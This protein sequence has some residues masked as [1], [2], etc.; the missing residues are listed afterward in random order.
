[1][2]NSCIYPVKGIDDELAKAMGRD[3]KKWASHIAVMRNLYEKTKG[4]KVD[5]EHMIATAEKFLQL[6]SQRRTDYLNTY[7]VRH[8]GTIIAEQHKHL[9]KVMD[10]YKR[11]RRTSLLAQLFSTKVDMQYMK[12]GNTRSRAEIMNGYLDENG[13][14]R[15]GQFRIFEEMRIDIINDISRL[16]EKGTAEDMHKAQEYMLMLEH[17]PALVTRARLELTK[18]EGIKLSATAETADVATFEDYDGNGDVNIA[19]ALDE[20]VREHWMDKAETRSAYGS[21]G[22]KVRM[23]LGRC[24]Q[25]NKEGKI[26]RDDI[27]IPVLMNPIRTHQLLQKQLRFCSSESSMMKKLSYI[28]GKNKG[29]ARIAWM[30]GIVDFL[31]E[32]PQ[33]RTIFFNDFNKNRTLYSALV[34]SRKAGSTGFFV[35]NLN[36]KPTAATDFYMLSVL[37]K[38]PINTATSIFDGNGYVN[39]KNLQIIRN[40]INNNFVDV[41]DAG[42][43]KFDVMT[44]DKKIESIMDLMER[45][46]M[47]I[48]IDAASSLVNDAGQLKR[49]TRNIREFYST[50]INA[51]LDVLALQKGPKAR[52]S[53]KE[54]LRT[55]LKDGSYDFNSEDSPFKGRGKVSYYEFLTTTREKIGSPLDY[56]SKLFETVDYYQDSVAYEAAAK[57][58]NEQGKYISYYPDVLPSYMA[59]RIENIQSFVKENDHK[60]LRKWIE[61]EFL[62]NNPFFAEKVDGKWV[63]F[64]KWIDELYQASLN[65]SVPLDERKKGKSPALTAVFEMTRALGS[66]TDVTEKYNRKQHMTDMFTRFF[67]DFERGNN[68]SNL[69]NMLTAWFPVFVL[70]DSNAH[71]Y[72]HAKVYGN[73]EILRGFYNIFRQE[74]RRWEMQLAL[75][76]DLESKGYSKL[77]NFDDRLIEVEEIDG[78]E[79]DKDA[80]LQKHGITLESENGITDREQFD[81]GYKETSVKSSSTEELQSEA[82]DILETSDEMDYMLYGSLVKI[83]EELNKRGETV[84]GKDNRELTLLRTKRKIIKGGEFTMLKFLNPWH[85]ANDGTVGKYY[86]M[87]DAE[88]SEQSVTNAIQAYLTDSEKEVKRELQKNKL[89]KKNRK[90]PYT[91][92]ALPS[93]INTK[94]L[95]TAIQ[96]Y[97]WNHAFATAQQLQMFTI[98]PAFYGLGV[99]K[100]GRVHG[101]SKD[102]QKRYKQEHA[103]G[104]P[105][106]LEAMYDDKTYVLPLTDE[107]E[108]DETY[109]VVYFDDISTSAEDTDPEMME[110]LK[111][112]YGKDSWEVDQYKD[113]SLTD[114]QGYRTLKGYRK[115]ATMLGEWTDEMTNAYNEIESIR[116]SAQGREFTT[117]EMQRIIDCAAVFQP[118]KPIMYGIEKYNANGV[119]VPIPVQHKYAEAIIIPELCAPNSRI[120][121]I[122]EWMD[123][124]NV[125]M[126]CSTKAVKVG[127]F[128][129]VDISEAKSDEDIDIALSKAYQHELR[130]SDWRKQTNVPNHV[131][132]SRLFGNQLRK[133]IMSNLDFRSGKLYNH[134]AGGPV[135]I[136][137]KKGEKVNLNAN[138]LVSFY[139]SLIYSNMKESFEEFQK[140]I[141]SSENISETLLQ[142]I[143]NNNRESEDHMLAVALEELAEGR[144]FTLALCE[145]G[146]EHDTAAMLW[147]IFRKMVNKQTIMGNSLVQV[148]ALGINSIK[149]ESE[150]NVNGGLKYQMSEDGENILWAEAEIPWDLVF[151]LGDTHIPLRWE[152]YCNADRTLKV[153]ENGIPLIEKVLPG[154]LDMIAY[155]IPTEREYSMV[156]LKVVRFAPPSE[157]GTIK[158]PAPAVTIAGFDFDIDKLYLMRKEFQRRNLTS[159][160]AGEIWKE[161]Y[162]ENREI[163]KALELAREQ[164]RGELAELLRE[165]II[166]SV[167][168]HQ[169]EDLQFKNQR[170]YRWWAEAGL[171]ETTGFATPEEAFKDFFA[172]TPTL[173]KYED[174]NPELTPEQNSRAA[175]NNMLLDIMMRRLEDPETLTARTTPGGFESAKQA[176]RILRELLYGDSTGLSLEELDAKVR[177]KT[178][179]DPEPDY[180]VLNPLTMIQYTQQ[181]QIASKL[182]GIFAN[183]NSNYA[184]TSI[185][186]SLKISEADPYGGR[187]SFAGHSYNDFLNP[188]LLTDSKGNVLKDHKGN[189]RYVDV[190]RL[191]AEFLAAS[192]DAVKD[193]VLNYLNLN[194]ITA[195]IGATL[196][197]LGYTMNE[198][199]LLLNQ[200]AIREVCKICNETGKPVD[201]VIRNICEEAKIKMSETYNPNKLSIENLMKEIED[202]RELERSAEV[203]SREDGDFIEAEVNWNG[204]QT[205]VL[206]LFNQLV[207]ISGDLSKL[208]TGTKFTASNAVDSTFGGV[209]AK[210]HKVKNFVKSLSSQT[211]TIVAEMKD[212]LYYQREDNHLPINSSEHLLSLSEKEYYDYIVDNPFG[213]EQAMFDFM[214]KTLNYLCKKETLIENGKAK[215]K[216]GYYPYMTDTY[217]RT[218]N[219]ISALTKSGNLNDQFINTL[220]MDMLVAMLSNREGSLFDG[221]SLVEYGENTITIRDY[222]QNHFASD[223][224]TTIM[225]REDLKNNLLFKMLSPEVTRDV[226]GAIENV[227][228]KLAN[229]GGLEE[230]TK[231]QLIEA[232]ENLNRE[233]KDIARNLFLYNFY[234]KGFSYGFNTFLNLAPTSL[235]LDIMIDDGRASK[236]V[237]YADFF[238]NVLNG[239]YNLNP[240]TFAR[241][242]IMNNS[243]NNKLVF[244]ADWGTAKKYLESHSEANPYYT[245][246]NSKGKKERRVRKVITI[247]TSKKEK[248]SSGASAFYKTTKIGD[249]LLYNF[250][251]AI[252]YDGL[253]YI[254]VGDMGEAIANKTNTNNNFEEGFTDANGFNVTYKPIMNYVVSE[255]Y[256][257]NRKTYRSE[258]L[259]EDVIA[260]RIRTKEQLEGYENKYTAK[261]YGKEIIEG[262]KPSE[263]MT[264]EENQQQEE[265]AVDEVTKEGY[266][267]GE[268]PE[269]INIDSVN[270]ALVALSAMIVAQRKKAK[271]IRIQNQQ[272]EIDAIKD[273]AKQSTKIP[274]ALKQQGLSP[275]DLLEVC[276]SQVQDQ[277]RSI[278]SDM[279]KHINNVMKNQKIPGKKIEV[280]NEEGKPGEFC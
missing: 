215:K 9:K 206:K 231:D 263:E 13:I 162:K 59:D 133:I 222:F 183:H 15:G 258:A 25:Y 149:T 200:P 207:G 167:Q 253:L 60:G 127:I 30:Q 230:V 65:E 160:E 132:E 50:G 61:K 141:G 158:L 111:R 210:I 116:Q 227:E 193:P 220:H 112:T 186:H 89:L 36:K 269:S 194:T 102:L 4:F 58:V 273:L 72:I 138:N 19:Q 145:P 260:N 212:P 101:T 108:F 140:A 264:T 47:Q 22:S 154:V 84:R 29:K 98:D 97:T 42:K 90:D 55:I 136:N 173:W 266:D 240:I 11:G 164:G 203:K 156:R 254:A 62:N 187:V 8:K 262:N 147:S 268:A 78:F 7:N 82:A 118:F 39:L 52:T 66:G 6:E 191:M 179:I 224:V 139:N 70:G 188:P 267:D 174:Y 199:G 121:R 171:K 234:K 190:A 113:T 157:G 248:D 57:Y 49:F 135:N 75:R 20:A 170:L 178:W 43:T 64:N 209:L 134:Y 48:D 185:M 83:I 2:G 14:R 176:A 106:S 128:G 115:I 18:W 198:I 166:D 244:N 99:D 165:Q 153:D 277:Y 205:D 278:D 105:P 143:I 68:G 181:N 242:L 125:D 168:I 40:I 236:E 74:R 123:N 256:D 249:R 217:V 243:D 204:I 148:S 208:V 119:V 16:W 38:K 114:G 238:R 159:E 257:K 120:K 45:L 189:D 124:N 93:C 31:N 245:V 32:S 235:K 252:M 276:V 56:L 95:D 218:R 51:F 73:N 182:I 81:K 21:L 241:Q 228:F 17:W 142:Y 63:I 163:Q 110:L 24:P 3:P 184:L 261:K 67:N 126:V 151:K 150:N 232:W 41:N 196:A 226:D 33:N 279:K 130:Y 216:G 109:K 77:K 161:F 233:D 86:K 246:E 12:P 192:V 219:F 169:I 54:A 152:D 117:E 225:Q 177:E 280:Y 197:R 80:V 211:S 10:P 202:F 129:E 247:D 28:S 271:V 92:E 91:F 37:E 237:S 272:E 239:E 44:T 104:L 88:H 79:L 94:N 214:R 23:M 213:Y 221:D 251:P 259:M 46:G 35:K 100:N 155:R 103:P 27:G 250:R 76:E 26:E 144:D 53:V 255:T 87:L 265:P 274:E 69:R 175:R 71:K 131:Q 107:G 201:I 223:L 229:N 146:M 34:P 5:R 137:G 195:D 85:K 96:I 122:A 270:D 275:L 172:R 180:D 1:M